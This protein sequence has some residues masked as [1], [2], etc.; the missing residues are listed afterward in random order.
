MLKPGYYVATEGEEDFGPALAMVMSGAAKSVGENYAEDGRRV[1]A[2]EVLKDGVRRNAEALATVGMTL[3]DRFFSNVLRDYAS[4]FGEKWWREAIQNGVDAGARNITCVTRLREDGNWVI[5]CEDDGSGMDQD[6]LVRAMLTLG[7]S[8]KEAGTSTFGGFGRAKELLLLPWVEYTIHTRDLS[9]TSRNAEPSTLYQV[10][11]RKGTLLSVVMPNEKHATPEEAIAYILKCR[12]PKVHFTVNGEVVEA[13][14][15]KGAKKIRELTYERDGRPFKAVIYT[16]PRD[17]NYPYDM[18][19]RLNGLFMFDRYVSRKPL[20]LVLVD[21]EGAAVDMLTSNRDSFASDVLRRDIDGYVEELVTE[22]QQA[23]EKKKGLVWEEFVGGERFQADTVELRQ[24]YARKMQ[25]ALDDASEVLSSSGGVDSM[26][27]LELAFEDF[28]KKRQREPPQLPETGGSRTG[29]W[30]A[31]VTPTLIADMAKAAR[32]RGSSDVQ[33]M[34]WVLAWRPDYAVNNEIEGFHVPRKFWPQSMTSDVRRIVKLWAEM[35]RLVLLLLGSRETFGVGVVFSR[36]TLGE[37]VKKNSDRLGKRL[38]WLLINP[39]PDF[40][41]YND[42]KLLDVRDDDALHHLFAVA[43][44]ECTHLANNVSDHDVDFAAA[45]TKNIALTMGQE[46]LLRTIRRE[47][48][49][50]DRE[51][52]AEIRVAKKTQVA[53]PAPP[54]EREPVRGVKAPESGTSV[55]FMREMEDPLLY[56]GTL[57]F[58]LLATWTE[59][60]D[61]VMFGIAEQ[62]GQDFLLGMLWFHY[63]GGMLIEINSTS[64]ETRELI[65]WPKILGSIRERRDPRDAVERENT[66]R[67]HSEMDIDLDRAKEVF[68][69][70]TD[71]PRDDLEDHLRMIR[72]LA[73][74]YERQH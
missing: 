47:V 60:L 65:D 12:L 4:S 56:P 7:G 51:V 48:I 6:T 31:P 63:E 67:I 68:A 64:W 27:D 29:E 20:D 26:E 72:I 71:Q 35:C 55:I 10:P 43:V 53:A 57:M 11:K 8:T 59:H 70:W 15:G 14:L 25:A 18:P 39:A 52:K 42:F 23:L 50:Y 2:F 40:R 16:D 5:S 17:T 44:H 13:K 73:E 28:A 33:A 74:A 32:K 45:L 22:K 61:P 3:G 66:T 21:L 1:I 36:N 46:K 30:E 49:K 34:A 9:Y 19:V 24:R 69:M 62:E 38:S 54:R 37:C 58:T 41:G